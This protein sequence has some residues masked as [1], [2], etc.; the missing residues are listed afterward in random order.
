M[1]YSDP[2]N[3]GIRDCL[4]AN[5]IPSLYEEVCSRVSLA[6][7]FVIAAELAMTRLSNYY[8]YREPFF[9]QSLGVKFRDRFKP[10]RITAESCPYSEGRLPDPEAGCSSSERTNFSKSLREVFVENIYS[11]LPEQTAWKFGAAVSGAHTVGSTTY[12]NSGFEGAWSSA[13]S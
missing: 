3:A 5:R 12:A 8:I 13:E 7:F 11:D 6:D 1:P 10:G 2:I 9:D 4:I